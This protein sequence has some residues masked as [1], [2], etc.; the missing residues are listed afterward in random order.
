[1]VS[2]NIFFPLWSVISCS[3]QRP[4]S[5]RILCACVTGMFGDQDSHLALFQ[6][7]PAL[8]ETTKTLLTLVFLFN[9]CF[10]NRDLSR[11]SH[12]CEVM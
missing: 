5:Q 4:I 12:K 11:S 10:I 3:S 1:M 8:M 6:Q 2:E 9:Y 7:D